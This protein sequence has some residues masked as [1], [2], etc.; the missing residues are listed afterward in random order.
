MKEDTDE[1]WRNG[2]QRAVDRKARD[3]K[4][5]TGMEAKEAIEKRENGERGA[6]RKRMADVPSWGMKI[7]DPLRAWN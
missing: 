6:E 3:D 1:E 7:R 2:R 5:E 4:K